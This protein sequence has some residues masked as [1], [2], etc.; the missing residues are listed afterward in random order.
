[1]KA[2]VVGAGLA[3]LGAATALAA[4]GVA[5]ELSEAAAQAGGRCRSYFDPQIGLVIDNGNHLVLSGNQAVHEYLARIGASDR[6]TGPVET[7]FPFVDLATQRAW[8]VRPN[9]GAVPWWILSPSR[10]V[11]GA[12]FTDFL[13]MAGLLRAKPGQRVD[14]AVRCQGPVWERLMRPFL[15]AA[16]NAEPESAAAEL[17]AQVI[18]ETLARG[19]AAYAPRVPSPGLSATFVNP[20]LD[21]LE[22]RGGTLRLQRRLLKL[23]T[24]G[25]R[26]TGLEF[27]DG[28]VEVAA[29]D[30]IILAVPP[31]VAKDLAPQLTTPERFEGIVNGHFRVRTGDGSARIIGVLNGTVEWIFCFEDRISVT[32]SGANRLMS[33]GREDLARQFWAD[34]SLALDLGPDLPPWQIIKERR[35]TFLATADQQA[36]RPAARTAYTNLVLAGDWTATGLPATIEGALRSGAR[37]A[38]LVQEAFA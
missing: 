36:R 4:R 32:V 6:L 12:K 9:A 28:L 14:E 37:A 27:S 8:T 5:V 19:G 38:G 15:L 25:E 35:A 23:R 10:G 11:P 20:A 26:V 33:T 7:Q 29:R 21:Y 3:G 34:V 13:A 16:L 18:R 22:A 17:A 24:D 30:R 31:W 1:M 2:H